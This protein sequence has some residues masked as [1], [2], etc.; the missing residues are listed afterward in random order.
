MKRA[1]P[2]RVNYND[3]IHLTMSWLNISRELSDNGQFTRSLIL[4]L[5]E[6]TTYENENVV[7]CKFYGGSFRVD[8]AH[9]LFFT[10][11]MLFVRMFLFMVCICFVSVPCALTQPVSGLS[12][13][14]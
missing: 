13:F 2:K 1:N 6:T 9:I 7:Y 12:C 4:F 5:N 14:M 8:F 11:S 10:Y 3:S